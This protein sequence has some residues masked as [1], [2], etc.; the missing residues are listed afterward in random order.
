[1]TSKF[2]KIKVTTLRIK[3]VSLTSELKDRDVLSSWLIIKHDLFNTSLNDVLRFT[4]I[5]VNRD[6]SFK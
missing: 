3:D 5:C 1:M 2:Y 6:A 4:V